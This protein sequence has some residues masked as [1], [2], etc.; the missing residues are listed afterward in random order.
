[1]AMTHAFDHL[2]ELTRLDDAEL[3][4]R[5][6]PHAIGVLVVCSRLLRAQPIASEALTPDSFVAEARQLNAE[7]VAGSRAL[8]EAIGQSSDAAHQRDLIKARRI[9]CDFLASCR[10]P[11]YRDI[12]TAR[13]ESLGSES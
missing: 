3:R 8:G 13:L 4:G 10:A 5:F 11:F 12:A 7:Y 2:R 1:V 9:L 6:G